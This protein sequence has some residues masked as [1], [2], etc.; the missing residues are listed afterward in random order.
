LK[1]IQQEGSSPLK[2]EGHSRR[3][4]LAFRSQ[5]RSLGPARK[6]T[7][8]LELP[9]NEVNPELEWA[10][11]QIPSQ[12]VFSPSETLSR[13]SRQDSGPMA[14]TSDQQRG[15]LVNGYC[16]HAGLVGIASHYR[17]PVQLSL[18]VF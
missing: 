4:G 2:M 16:F 12:T 6:W 17:K 11:K 18:T 3:L 7:S 5:E 1:Q 8:V 14:Q 13:E 15:R 10:W 9:E